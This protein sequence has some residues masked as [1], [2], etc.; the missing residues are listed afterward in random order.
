MPKARRV[1]ITGNPAKIKRSEQPIDIITKNQ[2]KDELGIKNNLPMVLVF[3]GSQGAKS[4]NEACIEIIRNSLN[5]NYQLVWASGQKQYD[6]IIEQLAKNNI[7]IE[8]MKNTKIVPYIYNMEKIMAIS[9]III[10]RSGA[11]TVTEIGIIGKPAIFVPY[12]FATEN[13]QEYNARVLEKNGAARVIL[14]EELTAEVLTK[15]LNN[16]LENKMILFEMG[17]NAKKIAIP[18]TL[19]LIYEEIERLIERD[20][21]NWTL[22][23]SNEV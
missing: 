5:D 3:G 22:N 14:D 11:M 10:A 17:E 19:D 13:H 23:N 16:M 18:N 21:N 15:A 6:S 4:I 8:N 7:H 20:D 2:I 1:V 9:D 12:P